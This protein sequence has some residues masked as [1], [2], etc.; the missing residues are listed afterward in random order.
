MIFI[1]VDTWSQYDNPEEGTHHEGDIKI[2]NTRKTITAF[3]EKL[4]PNGI[5][6]YTLDELTGKLLLHQAIIISL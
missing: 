5:V 4:W 1:Q 6:Y 2:S 3:K